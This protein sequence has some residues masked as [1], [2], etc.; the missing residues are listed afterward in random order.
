MLSARQVLRG[1]SAATR[2]SAAAARSFASTSQRRETKMISLEIDGKEVSV[3]QGT[4]LIQA[5]EI[6]GATIPR[7][8]CVSPSLLAFGRKLSTV[9][10]ALLLARQQLPRQ[11]SHCRCVPTT[12]SPDA[13][14]SSSPFVR[15]S[16]LIEVSFPR[17]WPTGNCRMCLV[18][19]SP[20]GLPL[21]HSFA[22]T[23]MHSD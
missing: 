20:G 6:A 19:V 4:A 5:C 23:R 15:D 9:D 13:C 18:E 16:P 8:W 12:P 21:L 7:F 3:P 1:G 17:W 10:C 14:A 22:L 11:T 2:R